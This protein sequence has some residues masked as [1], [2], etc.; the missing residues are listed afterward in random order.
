MR[1]LATI[2]LEIGLAEARLKQLRAE[3]ARFIADRRTQVLKEF[4]GGASR[5]QLID[6]YG[7][8]YSGLASLL[9]A[10]GRHERQRRSLGLTDAQAVEYRRLI[11]GGVPS[12]T[13]RNIA[14]ALN[15][16]RVYAAGP[17]PNVEV[18]GGF[19]GEA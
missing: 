11:R 15:E 6:R 14:I 9:N 19:S 10:A 5:S 18:G 8:T 13:A 12:R 3:R 7:L 16:G 1:T 2:Q 4:D 17:D